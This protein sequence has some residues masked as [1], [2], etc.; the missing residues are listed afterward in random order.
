MENN[1][2][3]EIV[4]LGHGEKNENIIEKPKKGKKGLIIILCL[5]FIIILLIVAYFIFINPKKIL[6]SLTDNL[7]TE[8]KEIKEEASE[9]ITSML[10]QGDITLNEMPSYLEDY[11]NTKVNYKVGYDTINKKALANLGLNMSGIEMSL[12]Y[13][14]QDNMSYVNV[15]GI[16]P[17]M[18]KIETKEISDMLFS[19]TDSKEKYDSLINTVLNAIKNSID[20]KKLKSSIAFK[21][22]DSKLISVKTTYSLNFSEINKVKNAIINSIINDSN[23]LNELSTLLNESIEETKERLNSELENDI[24]IDDTNVMIYTDIF[25]KE[26]YKI[27]FESDVE[28]LTIINNDTKITMNY[29]YS[30]SDSTE[31]FDIEIN[32]KDYSFTM[33]LSDKDEEI[34]AVMTITESNDKNAKGSLTIKIVPNINKKDEVIEI[35]ANFDL[36]TDQSFDSIDTSNAKS[37]DEYTT[38]ELQVLL[39]LMQGFQDMIPIDS[40]EF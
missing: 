20:A 12:I 7:K 29:L 31:K 27:L 39:Q 32:K 33:S 17:V 11:K 40:L 26:I 30:L 36:K 18:T 13:F 6:Y 1:N 14:L 34:N 15:P 25:G 10:F 9:E 35:S 37:I 28:K 8:I 38:D 22:K 19:Q 3:L 4:D 21:E 24:Y 16:L 2:D 5:L 23:S